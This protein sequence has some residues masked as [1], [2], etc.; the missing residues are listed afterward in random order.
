MERS[1]ITTLGSTGTAATYPVDLPLDPGTLNECLFDIG[2]W[3]SEHH[4]PHQ[5]RVLMEPRDG[6]I[7]VS[8]P[9]AEDANAFRARFGPRLDS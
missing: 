5:A 4:I 2:L 3:L 6:R 7:R 1:R 8:F 9:D